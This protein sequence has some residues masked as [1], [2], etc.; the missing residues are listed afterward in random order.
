MKYPW[1]QTNCDLMTTIQFLCIKGLMNLNLDNK[2]NS[3][4]VIKI[5]I[6]ENLV[7]HILTQLNY[8]SLAFINA[9][10]KLAKFFSIQVNFCAT[11][12]VWS[13]HK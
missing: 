9:N 11:Q 6:S 7:T 12:G 1:Q 4:V 13:C 5:L 10:T 2:D 3:N 8:D